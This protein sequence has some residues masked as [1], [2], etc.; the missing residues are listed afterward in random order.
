MSL[1]H[2][3]SHSQDAM[4][5]GGQITSEKKHANNTKY[6]IEVTLPDGKKLLYTNVS[7]ELLEYCRNY[8]TR[9]TVT[10]SG[11]SSGGSGLAD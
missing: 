6:T 5:Q 2:L 4:H 9:R 3:A 11:R 10:V 1:Q 8:E 7:Q